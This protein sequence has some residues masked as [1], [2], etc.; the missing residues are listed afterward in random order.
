MFVWICPLGSAALLSALRG[1]A[2][3]RVA[4]SQ[5]P[6]RHELPVALPRAIWW[7]LS[8]ACLLRGGRHL[9]GTVSMPTRC[10]NGRQND[11][12]RFPIASRRF[13]MV[14]CSRPGRQRRLTPD[15]AQENERRSNTSASDTNIDALHYLSAHCSVRHRRPTCDSLRAAFS[16]IVSI[17]PADAAID[18]SR[19]RSTEADDCVA[20]SRRMWRTHAVYV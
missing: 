20:D 16:A 19:G 2:G 8:V 17:M 5:R 4:W 1:A 13:I 6:K 12:G 14:R 11:A 9:S 7:R 10:L 3:R 18:R 15:R